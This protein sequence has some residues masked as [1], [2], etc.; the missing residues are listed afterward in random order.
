MCLAEDSV[1]PSG[2]EQKGPHAAFDAQGG[3]GKSGEAEWSYWKSPRRYWKTW[4]QI[5]GQFDLM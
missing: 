4:A 1:A 5:Q 2:T 3:G